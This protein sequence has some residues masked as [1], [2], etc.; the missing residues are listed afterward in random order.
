MRA[1]VSAAYITNKIDQ[2]I[3]LFGTTRKVLIDTKK[4]SIFNIQKSVPLKAYVDI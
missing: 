2:T 1:N 4:K 3:A